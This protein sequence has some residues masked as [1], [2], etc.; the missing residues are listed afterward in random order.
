MHYGAATQRLP[1]AWRI[2]RQSASTRFI[3]GSSFFQSVFDAA[4]A[5]PPVAGSSMKSAHP[6]LQGAEQLQ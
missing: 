3:R 6:F 1:G 5:T 2:T 4:N